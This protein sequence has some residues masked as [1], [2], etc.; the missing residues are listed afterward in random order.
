MD[1]ELISNSDLLR[2]EEKINSFELARG[3][4]AASI[5]ELKRIQVEAVEA[6]SGRRARLQ[7]EHAVQRRDDVSC[8]DLTIKTLPLGANVVPTDP[9]GFGKMCYVTRREVVYTIVDKMTHGELFAKEVRQDE[10]S[11]STPNRISGN[12]QSV[13]YVHTQPALE[14]GDE[15]VETFR[16]GAVVGLDIAS[17]APRVMVRDGLTESVYAIDPSRACVVDHLCDVDNAVP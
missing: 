9:D 8:A 14:L 17:A 6:L 15:D 16:S 3:S 12:H 4:I 1:K 7:N 10:L 13:V 11:F 2:I 5:A